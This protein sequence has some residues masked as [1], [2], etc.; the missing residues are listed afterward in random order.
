MDKKTGEFSVKMKSGYLWNSNPDK[1][2]IMSDPIAKGI[3]KM[4]MFSQISIE[5]CDKENR[6]SEDM[7]YTNALD[8]GSINLGV[9]EKNGVY[10]AVYKFVTGKSYEDKYIT[11]PVEYQIKN[12]A[13][14]VSIDINKIQENDTYHL[15]NVSIL[16]FFGAGAPSEKGYI[17]VPDGSG[18]LIDFNSATTSPAKYSAFIYDRD[19]SMKTEMET[20]VTNSVRLPVLGIKKDNDAFLAVVDQGDA[21]GT[22]NALVSG[23]NTSWNNAYFTFQYREFD[24]ITLDEMTWN[25]RSLPYLGKVN[26][27][28][29][30]FTI[31]YYFLEGSDADYVGMATVNRDYL[32]SKYKIKKPAPTKQVPFYMDVN[33]SV[34]KV[35]PVLGLPMEVT[36]PLTTFNELQSMLERFKKADIDDLVVKMDGW[37]P[38]GVHGEIP[39]SASAESA[40]G[41]NGAFS[42]L[43]DY[44]KADGT[45]HL[46]PSANFTTVYKS[47]NGFIPL[48]QAG[49]NISGA[50]AEQYNFLQSTGL[51]DVTKAPWY[52]VNPGYS[53][54]A[55]NRFENNLKSETKTTGAGIAVDGYGD[56]LYSDTYT[57]V[58]D[59]LSGRVPA[60]R[61]QALNMWQEGLKLSEQNFKSLL[62]SGGNSYAVPFAKDIID[63]PMGSSMFNI[64]TEQ[65]PYYQIVMSGMVETASTPVN[66]NEDPDTFLL[67]CLET[68]TY[69]LYSFTARESS[70]VKDSDLNNIY[71][72]QYT[73]WFDDAV[74]SYAKY[75]DAYEKISGQPIVKRETNN[76]IVKTTYQNGV[77]ISIDYNKKTFSLTEGGE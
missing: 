34:K 22:V 56:T 38:G 44:A 67:Q 14:Q 31:D 76:N 36:E 25:E 66:F 68:G 19:S 41:G 77:Q 6:V 62:I 47:G 57:S 9:T 64:C 71:N 12:G 29:G 63:I 46:Y 69:P 75:H 39:N 15:L 59:G 52:L 70:L 26:T 73:L 58:I 51:K 61:A 60:D 8:S 40:I 42:K 2:Q 43:L 24:T 54:A 17:F 4:S 1:D 20:D 65:V 27:G 74:K 33:M 23:I 7:S 55:L 13:L 49:R 35:E 11:I 32:M 50:L 45:I 16:P 5:Y 10:T 30:K 21:L 72:S 48:L 18:A 53:L 37:L 28:S 3:N